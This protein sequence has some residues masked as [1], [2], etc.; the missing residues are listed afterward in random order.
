MVV[1]LFCFREYFSGYSYSGR[2]LLLL[3]ASRVGRPVC[4]VCTDSVKAFTNVFCF[5]SGDKLFF[6]LIGY[7]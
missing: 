3:F 1:Y 2:G 5:P 7:F 4:V 6:L